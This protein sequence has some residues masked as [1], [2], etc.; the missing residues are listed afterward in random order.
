[1]NHAA[2]SGQPLPPRIAFI[3]G[4]GFGGATTFLC[5]LAGELS[6]RRVSVLVVSPEKEN[7]FAAGFKAAGVTTI[8]HDQRRMIFEDRI[9]AMLKVL[10]EFRPTVVVSCL[11]ATSYEVLR[12][13]P[14][15]IHRMGLVHTDAPMFYDAISPYA[16][17]MDAA[18]GISSRITRHLGTMEE[19]RKVAKVCLLHGVNIPL[20]PMSRGTDDRPLRILY[21]GR[22]MNPQKRV[23]LFPIILADLRQSGIPFQWSIVG[24]GNQRG[25]LERRMMSDDPR[26]QIIFSGVVPNAR[27]PALL[28]Q[29]DIF[30]LASD[31]EGLP[32][33]LL[34]A[35]AHG[36]VPVVSDLESG[37]RDVVD[38]ANGLLVP[39]DDVAG[40]A[41]AIIHLHGHRDELAAKSAAAR[42]R[43]QTD[44]SVAAMTD[45]WL[46]A[47]PPPPATPPVWPHRWRISAPL[48]A[49]N[50]FHFSA[51]MRLL[52]RA[53]VRLRK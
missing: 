40:Y 37:I 52:R 9:Q 7:P 24:E 10:A 22:I 34:E 38:A 36:V 18:V 1:M 20:M 8:L 43:V 19:F 12:Y 33:S 48:V 27:V 29:H 31:A 21:F 46:A 45:R 50:L 13:L 2:I 6:H 30:L 32:I 44:F 26:Q 35:M 3:S 11:G 53:A 4:L 51:P 17:C 25:E 42:A 28:E 16:G 47:F 14:S 15:G 5:N 39:V 49:K 23:H 41:R